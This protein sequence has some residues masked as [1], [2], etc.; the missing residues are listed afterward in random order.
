MRAVGSIACTRTTLRG[1]YTT[2]A[3][4]F[5]SRMTSGIA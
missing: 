3:A 4:A 1:L 5:G 2:I